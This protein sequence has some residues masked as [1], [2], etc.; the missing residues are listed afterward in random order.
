MKSNVK[1]KRVFPE[2]SSLIYEG[3]DKI[4]K[5][6]FGKMLVHQFIRNKQIKD[7]TK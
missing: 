2:V 7:T 1:I 5:Q 6:N 4:T 3:L